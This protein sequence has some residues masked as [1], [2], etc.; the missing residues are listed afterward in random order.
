MHRRPR[1]RRAQRR[2]P[3]PSTALRAS[4]EDEWGGAPLAGSGTGVEDLDFPCNR[5]LSENDSFATESF[6]WQFWL[7]TEVI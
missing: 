2:E 4:M 1:A 7:P 5:P 6:E 3:Q